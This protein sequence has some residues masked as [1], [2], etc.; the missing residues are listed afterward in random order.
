MLYFFMALTV[1]PLSIHWTRRVFCFEKNESVFDDAPTLVMFTVAAVVICLAWPLLY[2]VAV[3][4]QTYQIYASKIDW[5]KVRTTLC[6]YTKEE[7]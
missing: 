6:E 4:V 7:E 1:L 2:F 3:V 5:T